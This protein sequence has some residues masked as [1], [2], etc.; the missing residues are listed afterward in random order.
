VLIHGENRGAPAYLC[1]CAESVAQSSETGNLQYGLCKT[2]WEQRAREL[3]FGLTSEIVWIRFG[4]FAKC[5]LDLNPRGH[6][7]NDG[8]I[9]Q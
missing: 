6:K 3:W 5:S 1:E 9:Y 4:V 7:E 2:R 8:V